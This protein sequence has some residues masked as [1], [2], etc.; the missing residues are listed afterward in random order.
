[1]FHIVSVDVTPQSFH[2]HPEQ[3]E[4]DMKWSTKLQLGFV[5]KQ[6]YNFSDLRNFLLI[7]ET[8][9]LLLILT[10]F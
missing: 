2:F 10:G 5:Q 4:L 8:F 9:L 7:V 1:M 3:I 6:K